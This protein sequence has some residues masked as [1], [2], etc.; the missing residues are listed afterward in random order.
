MKVEE[1]K[2]ILNQGLELKKSKRLKEQ[3]KRLESDLV[4]LEDYE[5]D[6]GVILPNWYKGPALAH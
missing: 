2:D 5:R 6:N 1:A 3:L 4:L